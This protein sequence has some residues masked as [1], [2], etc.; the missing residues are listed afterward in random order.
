MVSIRSMMFALA[1]APIMVAA[2]AAWAE[3]PYGAV[4]HT[5]TEAEQTI[6]VRVTRPGESAVSKTLE[7]DVNKTAILE[8]EQDVDDILVANPG[9]ADVLARSKRRIA[10][11]G[12]GKGE[13]GIIFLDKNGNEV[14]VARRD[15]C[16][17]GRYRVARAHQQTGAG[18]LDPC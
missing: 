11:M 15:R 2:G 12:R 4:D 16:G 14:S 9:I 5:A 7:I 8:F 10:V 18:V 1:A 6:H 13:S 3:A 17:A